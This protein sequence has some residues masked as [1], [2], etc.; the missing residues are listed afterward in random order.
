M[1]S[2]VPSPDAE[3][4]HP[5]ALGRFAVPEMVN[6]IVV[7]VASWPLALPEMTTFVMQ[8]AEN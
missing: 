7:A 2:I 5:G 6:V 8:T 3:N 4:E 1:P